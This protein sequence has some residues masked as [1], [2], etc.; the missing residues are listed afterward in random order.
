MKHLT[1]RLLLA[2][3]RDHYIFSSC[4]CYHGKERKSS[5]AAISP[6]CLHIRC[7]GDRPSEHDCAVRQTRRK[8]RRDIP[9]PPPRHGSGA[10]VSGAPLIHLSRSTARAST[11]AC[12]P[13]CHR[14]GKYLPRAFA[15]Y[16]KWGANCLVALG[17]PVSSPECISRVS[18]EDTWVQIW[19]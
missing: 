13:G 14:G 7:H 1:V 9:P 8:G 12:V 3:R 5:T 16:L 10:A 6:R 15:T 19:R 17:S 18:V 4:H 11:C 2:G